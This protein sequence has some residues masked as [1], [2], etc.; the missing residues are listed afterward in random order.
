MYVV[1]QMLS[2]IVSSVLLMF[3]FLYHLDIQLK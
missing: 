3:V 1:S 2:L